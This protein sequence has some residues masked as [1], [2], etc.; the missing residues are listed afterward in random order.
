MSWQEHTVEKSTTSC[1]EKKKKEGGRK[2]GGHGQQD[3]SELGVSE[4]HVFTSSRSLQGLG[5]RATLK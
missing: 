2:G 1:R 4:G 5:Y 3:G